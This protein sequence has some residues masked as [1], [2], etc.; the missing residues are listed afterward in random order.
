MSLGQHLTS[1][2]ATHQSAGSLA[3]VAPS[4]PPRRAKRNSGGSGARARHRQRIR[5]F[6]GGLPSS[7]AYG[8]ASPLL[9]GQKLIFDD[10]LPP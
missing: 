5:L 8:A 2:P 6:H 7:S 10:V 4:G 1:E 3:E 9:Q